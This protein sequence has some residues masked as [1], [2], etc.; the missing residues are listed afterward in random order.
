MEISD[1]FKRL[2]SIYFANIS[3]NFVNPSYQVTVTCTKNRK[4]HN[5]ASLRSEQ[6][7]KLEIMINCIIRDMKSE[8][9]IDKI[10]NSLVTTP[11][12]KSQ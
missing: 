1:K 12:C 3:E 2:A 4:H 5:H 9:I 8:K 11:N 7:K 6:R 10:L